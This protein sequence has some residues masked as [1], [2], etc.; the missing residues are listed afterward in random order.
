[1]EPIFLQFLLDTVCAV[2]EAA[3]ETLY[4]IGHEFKSDWVMNSYIPRAT[5]MFTRDQQNYLCRISILK[6]VAVFS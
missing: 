5:E 4:L 2:R 3:I 1:M 6:S